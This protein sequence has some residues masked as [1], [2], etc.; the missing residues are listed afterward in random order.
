[1]GIRSAEKLYKKCKRTVNR[2]LG[3]CFLYGLLKSYIRSVNR[4]LTGSR[5][6]DLVNMSVQN[7][8]DRKPNIFRRLL[9]SRNISVDTN[10][11]K[12]IEELYGV[13]LPI[14]S[15]AK[16]YKECKW[17]V[18]RFPGQQPQNGPN[19]KHHLLIVVTMQQPQD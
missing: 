18:N 6:N 14:W 11:H 4:L 16:L 13:V 1:M 17:T 8:R 12:T 5:G 15:A 3:R 19:R 10:M 2:F 9:I 7:G